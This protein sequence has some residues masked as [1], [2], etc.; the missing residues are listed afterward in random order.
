MYSLPQSRHRKINKR[1]KQRSTARAAASHGP[2]LTSNKNLRI[3]SI[4]VI[5]VLAIAVVAYLIAFN[6]PLSG[7]QE[8][9]TQ[10]GLK[11]IDE[12]VGDGPTPK[13]GQTVTVNYVGTTQSTGVEFDNSYKRN[14]PADFKIGVGQV[15]KG[16]DEGLMT[17]KVG[18]KRKL[19]IPG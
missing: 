16:W 7:S 12:R 14:Q 2:S 6:R 9:T 10:S 19:I 4:I 17:M 15:I 3:G 8:V 1:K 11:Y 5:A 18:G 13:P